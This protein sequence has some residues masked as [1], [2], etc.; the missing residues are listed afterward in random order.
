MSSPAASCSS[1]STARR[2]SHPGAAAAHRRGARPARR[3]DRL[4]GAPAHAGLLAAER[5][6]LGA[7][8][9]IDPLGYL[10]F[11]ALA[12]QARV[13]LTDSGGLQKEAYWYGVP[14]VTLR[15]STEWVDTVE[16]GANV[17]VDDD[18]DAIER[19]R[20]GS[21]VPGRRAAA[22]RRRARERAHGGGSVRLAPVTG[23]WDVAI[24]GAGYVGL[25]LAQ[26]FADAGQRV[27]LVDVVPELVEA[28]NRGESHIEDVP[29]ERLRPHIDAGRITATLDYEQLKQAARDPD[30]AADAAH[31]AA[32]ARPG[33]RRER[34][35]R[36]RGGAPARPGRRARVDDLPGHDP[37]GRAADPRGRQRPQG[38]QGLPSRDVARAR[39]PG[40]HRLDDEDDP[41]GRRRADAGLHRGRGGRLPHRDRHRAR[42]LG[43]RSRP[44]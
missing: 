43:A 44:S 23:T 22:L 32:R 4:P 30:R 36:R 5:L 1:P 34:R 14:C 38:G 28:M 26:T 42:G 2:T 31:Q 41:E 16:A 13:I 8:E 40:P 12:S 27:L 9:P 35:A 37:R 20:R 29:S 15:P 3:A 10:D 7:F 33:I 17:L 39:R 18:P 24:I 21:P 6:G 11:A 25:P 19:R